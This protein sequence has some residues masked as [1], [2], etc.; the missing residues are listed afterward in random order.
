MGHTWDVHRDYYRMYSSVT[1]RLDVAKLL[2]IQDA[3]LVADYKKQTL[4]TIDVK[5]VQDCQFKG[6]IRCPY[7]II[8]RT[9]SFIP[10]ATSS[11]HRGAYAAFHVSF[12]GAC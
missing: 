11:N 3:G 5:K 6:N 10:Y 9:V 1:E 12:M 2:L 4:D 7:L 8:G